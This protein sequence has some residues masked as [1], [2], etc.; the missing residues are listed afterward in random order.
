VLKDDKNQIADKYAAK[1]TPEIY[2]LDSTGKLVYHGRIDETHD[3]PAGVK[4]PDLKNA[5][6]A[7]LGGRPIPSA[8]TKAFGC[9]IKRI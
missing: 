6:E 3:D 8:Q 5:M 9:S 2:M 1:K 4:S 7:F